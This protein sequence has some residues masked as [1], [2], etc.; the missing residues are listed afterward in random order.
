MPPELLLR[1]LE[2]G[3]ATLWAQTTTTLGEVTLHAIAERVLH[4]ASE[5]FPFFA[6]LKIE[7]SGRLQ[8]S[9]LRETV[10]FV[11]DVELT[12][13][14]RFVLVEFLTVL[15]NVTAEVLTPELYAADFA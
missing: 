14:V 15:G 13:G 8:C 3:F 6:S 5:Q 2:A 1:L 4:A 11:H 10:R 12:A 9:E 7:P